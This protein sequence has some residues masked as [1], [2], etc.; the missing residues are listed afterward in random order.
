MLE[1]DWDSP[2]FAV[3][4]RGY[5]A[6]TQD[7]LLATSRLIAGLYANMSDFPGVLCAHSALLC[8]SQFFRRRHGD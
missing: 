4:L 2:R 5:S 7:E 1:H 8:R 6:Q 3:R